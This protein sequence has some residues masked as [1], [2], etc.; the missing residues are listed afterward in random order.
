MLYKGDSVELIV[1]IVAAMVE[2]KWIYHAALQET[3]ITFLASITRGPTKLLNKV[4]D[5]MQYKRYTPSRVRNI[6]Y[7]SRLRR[8]TTE[9]GGKG[10]GGVTATDGRLERRGECLSNQLT[11]LIAA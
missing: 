8:V 10:A 4:L 7:E 11:G 9:S 6:R 3:V 5:G 1:Y 2:R